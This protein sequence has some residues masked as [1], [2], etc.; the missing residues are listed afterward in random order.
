[1]AEIRHTLAASLDQSLVSTITRDREEGEEEEE[2]EEE[3]EGGGYRYPLFRQPVAHLFSTSVDPINERNLTIALARNGE[4][5]DCQ[6]QPPLY[7]YF[8]TTLLCFFF[9]P[10]S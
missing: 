9:L 7:Y 10:F 1:M 2:E 4:K 6:Q 8:L 3:G 5:R